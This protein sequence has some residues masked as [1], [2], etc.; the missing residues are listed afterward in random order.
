MATTIIKSPGESVKKVFKYFLIA[1]VVLIVYSLIRSTIFTIKYGTVG[2]M[3]RFDKVTSQ[4]LKPGLHLKVPI[5][6]KVVIYR[7]QKIIYETAEADVTSNADYQD[8][9]VDTTTSDGQ[10]VSLRYTIRFSVDEDKATFVAQNIGTESEVVEK[11]V[12]TDSRIHARSIPRKYEAI[13][14]YSG[15]VEEVQSEITNVLRPI[16]EDNGLKL[17]EFGIRSINF[18]N[19]YVDAI[20]QKQIESEK[21]KTEEYRA[22]QEEFK[23][24]A[25]ITQ[26]EGE[27]AAQRLQQA[28]LTKAFLQKLYLEKWNGI[29]PQVM[30]GSNQMIYDLNMK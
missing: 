24:K 6:D 29:L 20:E 22:Q 13:D 4:V 18:Q 2:V 19:E 14:L 7:T 17:D 12:K 28:T 16:F 21:V 25:R 8:Y 15:N 1:I 9:P 30:S 23:K 27:A 11:I 10:Q 26:A 3:T 5:V